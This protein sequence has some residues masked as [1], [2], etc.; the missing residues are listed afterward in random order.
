MDELSSSFSD[1]KSN[2]A[3][4]PGSEERLIIALDFGTTYSGVSYCFANQRDPKI[5]AVLNWPGKSMGLVFSSW[6]A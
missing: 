1:L 4:D 3:S 6:K 2:D 5:S